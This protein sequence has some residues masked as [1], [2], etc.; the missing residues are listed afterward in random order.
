MYNDHVAGMLN[1]EGIIRWEGVSIQDKLMANFP[2]KTGLNY[3]QLIKVYN[4]IALN[5]TGVKEAEEIEKN[6]HKGYIDNRL[7]LETLWRTK[8]KYLAMTQ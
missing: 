8:A 2:G 1:N 7:Y 3:E 4:F 6:N 5:K